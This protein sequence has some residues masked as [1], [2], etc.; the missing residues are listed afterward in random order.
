MINGGWTENLCLSYIIG[1][2]HHGVHMTSHIIYL[3]TIIY[4]DILISYLHVLLESKYLSFVNIR[5]GYIIT[6]GKAIWSLIASD[7]HSI[8]INFD[9]TINKFLGFV[10]S[11]QFPFSKG[12]WFFLK[13]GPGVLVAPSLNFLV[14]LSLF[15]R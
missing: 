10:T 8:K 14:F 15:P 5:W 9:L 4:N 2:I 13:L 6:H 11:Q 1:H 12:F 3:L 7:V